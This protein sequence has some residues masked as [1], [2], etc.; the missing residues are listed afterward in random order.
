MDNQCSGV[1]EP[2]TLKQSLDLFGALNV[3]FDD[4]N[5]R[6]GKTL[7]RRVSDFLCHKYVSKSLFYDG[8]T[9]TISQNFAKVLCELAN[10]RSVI[11]ENTGQDTYGFYS[12][13][14]SV[15]IDDFCV[16]QCATLILK[17]LP[18][19]YTT[20]NFLK[21]QVE[22]KSA[23]GGG[24]WEN[25][26]CNGGG[27]NPG[28]G[29]ALN[30]WLTNSGPTG[31]PSSSSSS[32]SESSPTLL[33]GG[34][35]SYL[36]E[37]PGADLVT[38]LTNLISDS[39]EGEDGFLQYLV[40]D[41]AV[42]T[43]WSPCSTAAC[44]VVLRA[45]CSKS[46]NPL[47]SEIGRHTELKQA[48]QTVYS[49]CKPLAPEQEDE[50]DDAILTA[51][52]Y[53]SP[54]A[55]SK[56]LQ[57]V[58]LKRYIAWLK[59]KLDPLIYSL[60]LLKTDSL[61]WK[62]EE[63]LN[64]TISGPFGYGFSFSEKWTDWNED[65]AKTYI[66][67]AIT[68]LVREL[69]KL[70]D[71]VEKHFD[72]GVSAETSC[73]SFHGFASS[74]NAGSS[75]QGSS[76]SCNSGSSGTLT[77]VPVPK[78]LKDAIDWFLRVSGGDGVDKCGKG[79]EGLRNE[80]QKLLG[81]ADLSNFKNDLSNLKSIITT[82]ADGLKTLIGYNGENQPIKNGIASAKY[83]SSYADG[84]KWKCSWNS[85]SDSKDQNCANIFLGC[86]PLFYYGVT[87]L[88][89]RSVNVTGCKGDWELMCFNGKSFLNS[90]TLNAL[91]GFMVAVGYSDPNQLSSMEGE[92]VM[93]EVHN[94]LEELT[95]ASKHG[96]SKSSYSKYMGYLIQNGKEYL[97]S[98]PKTCPLYALYYV[99]EAYWKSVSEQSN[100]IPAA[101]NKIKEYLEELNGSSGPYD[102]L[103]HHIEEL[104]EK[105]K[106][107]VRP[108]NGSSE[109]R[110]GVR[111][112]PESSGTVKSSI[113]TS[114]LSGIGSGGGTGGEVGGFVASAAAEVHTGT[115]GVVAG[116]HG[117]EGSAGKNGDNAVSGPQ[118]QPGPIGARGPAGPQNQSGEKGGTGEQGDGGTNDQTPTTPPHATSSVAPAAGTVATLALGGGAAAV[119]FNVGGS[120]TILKGL[121]RIH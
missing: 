64:A 9:T 104:T 4:L 17:C 91:N 20:L 112:T 25:Q 116:S 7:E 22:G 41:L 14:A 90:N 1:L 16:E 74:G 98:D 62:K 10:V 100:G 42:I 99:A 118:G 67:I 33:P 71:I 39:G 34:Y 105:V 95:K 31:L 70:R 76:V 47:E 2:K 94:K 60:N 80:V 97:N 36:S 81:N 23:L 27:D 75:Q 86:V 109:P 66:P 88:Y 108:S 114:G 19:L 45:F 65:I 117:P 82:V 103:E 113:W 48:S 63:L 73:S 107:F 79:I 92:V 30:Q 96:Y 52:F 58:A 32:L 111:L 120:G 93:R 28:S 83:K 115:G 11:V 49:S 69:I 46:S 5:G 84:E 121:L 102:T 29:T 51:L 110:S 53:G 78:N 57:P 43:E 87:Y 40:L 54:D 119:Y 8:N 59:N 89:W 106:A 56:C 61:G 77:E 3:N 72:A 37:N 12:I 21:F 35:E 26:R 18:R 13:L 15:S 6:V 101:V 24:G 50:D 85:D 68:K 55:Y 38:P 44:L